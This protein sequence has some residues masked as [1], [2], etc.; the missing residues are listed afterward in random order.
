MATEEFYHRFSKRPK[1]NQKTKNRIEVFYLRRIKGLKWAV[2][3]AV[4]ALYFSFFWVSFSGADPAGASITNLSTDFG[5]SGSSDS[6]TDPGGTITTISVDVTQQN[7]GWKA[8]I[9]NLSGRLV[10]RNSDG[11]SIYEWSVEDSNLGGNIFVT[12]ASSVN[13]TPIGCANNSEILAEDVVLGLSSSSVDSINGTFN[14]SVHD[15]MDIGAVTIVADSC[16]S[17]ATYVNGSAQVINGTNSISF[18]EILLHDG[19]NLVYATVVDQDS[20]GYD[21]NVTHNRTY[22]FQLIVAENKSDSV[23]HAYYFYADISS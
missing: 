7:S 11:Q 15:E 16:N 3:L 13:W 4:L 17:T 19:T 8:Y 10:L 5:P 23:G 14:Y 12:R 1:P 21:A 18:Q 2:F 9:G 20:F 6:R 22:D